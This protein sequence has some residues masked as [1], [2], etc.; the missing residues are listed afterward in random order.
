[1]HQRT[2]IYECHA[3]AVCG[4]N[5]ERVDQAFLRLEGLSVVRVR[6]YRDQVH[7]ER[8]PQVRATERFASKARDSGCRLP[9]SQAV[10]LQTQLR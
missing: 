9:G 1:M 3:Q 4:T 10:L 5:L 2:R 8:K 6:G 7:F